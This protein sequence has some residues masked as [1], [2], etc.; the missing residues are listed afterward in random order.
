[1]I[2]VYNTIYK[3]IEISGSSLVNWAGK[4]TNNA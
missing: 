1:M 3:K 2:K 4:L